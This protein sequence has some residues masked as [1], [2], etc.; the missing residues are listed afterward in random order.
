MTD[1]QSKVTR[2]PRSRLERLVSA[3]DAGTPRESFE[4]EPLEAISQVEARQEV[5]RLLDAKPPLPCDVLRARL[6]ALG[7]ADR[8]LVDQ[9]LLRAGKA[10]TVAPT[11]NALR[12][13]VRLG[14]P[15][16][17]YE[18]VAR[19]LDAELPGSDTQGIALRAHNL[20][21]AHGRVICLPVRPTCTQCCVA[22]RCDYRG[23]GLDPSARLRLRV[24][25][26]P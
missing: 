14:Y 4:T 2:R 13:V 24:I 7:I 22:E 5:L 12:V 16:D 1:F 23:E 15:G 26:T 17:T 10:G 21:D 18:S 25:K 3:L 11:S 6:E 9:L 19:A 8:A 20:L